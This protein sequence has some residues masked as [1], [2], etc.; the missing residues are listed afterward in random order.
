MRV[1]NNARNLRNG[2]IDMTEENINELLQACG[3]GKL[4]EA[5]RILSLGT[6]PDATNAVGYTPLMSASRSYRVE[7][8]EELLKRNA[9]PN[10]AAN[11]GLTALHCAVGSVPSQPDRQ[12]RCVQILLNAGAE[13]S[14]TTDTGLTPL[15]NAAW[16]GCV[17][18]TKVILAS[19]VDVSLKDKQKR[20][21]YD[22]AKDRKHNQIIKMI[23]A[24]M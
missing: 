12:A 2:F 14:P 20:S 16:F 3:D 5:V 18:A 13:P 11:D 22:L 9:D 15:M 1:L 10:M 7:V 6:S 24:A 21:A 23:E 19:A 8:V 4:D 17:E